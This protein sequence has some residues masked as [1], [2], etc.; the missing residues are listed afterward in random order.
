MSLF[1]SSTLG[2]KPRALPTGVAHGGTTP[3][4]GA[5]QTEE[6]LR[7]MVGPVLQFALR[8]IHPTSPLTQG[9]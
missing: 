7:S 1:L 2:H 8:R 6:T 3:V 4:T 9:L 5:S